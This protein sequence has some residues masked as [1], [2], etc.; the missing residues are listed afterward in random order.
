MREILF[1]GKRLDNGEWAEGNLFILKQ[2]QSDIDH[3]YI[4]PTNT[5]CLFCD[6][7]YYAVEVDPDTIGQFTGLTANGKKI[8]EGDIVSIRCEGDAE[9]PSKGQI[10]YENAKIYF[11]EIDCGWFVIFSDG[12][13][14]PLAEYVN[15]DDFTVI[16]NIHDNPELLEVEE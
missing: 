2:Y 3:Y 4:L 1:S 10:W 5:V 8:F 14:L 11:S 16:G 12:Y 13:E 9:P 6:I 15:C 7:F